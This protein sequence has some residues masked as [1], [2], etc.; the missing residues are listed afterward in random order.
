MTTAVSL[1]IAPVAGRIGARID[2]VRLGP[3][4][5]P[6]T[7]T[8][9]RDALLR[10]KV[11]FLPGQHHL[12]DAAHAG[13][14]RLLGELTTA[15]PTVPAVDGTAN[16]LPLDAEAG[17]KANQWHT[18]VTF[19][20]APPAFSVL[21]AVTIPPYG[22]DTSWA[23]TVTAYEELPPTLREL[24]ERLWALHSNLYDYAALKPE[25][26]AAD[27]AHYR[28]VF[29]RI[30][31]ETEHPV[32]RVHPETGERSLL[33][34]NFA[35]HLLGVP[36]ADSAHLIDLLQSHVSRLENTV[37]WRWSAG[38]VAIWDNRATQHYA[39]DDYGD[40][41][42]R[43][44]RVTIAGDVPVGVHGQRSV[45]RTGDATAYHA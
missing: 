34:G 20:D 37:R 12:D 8:A 13:F 18:D 15:H 4:L 22:G 7:V 11:I 35:Q 28:E 25:A 41:P 29:T 39:I 3:D 27:Q 45:S 9:I 32:V 33:L 23:N 31:F 44:H 5:D 17:G 16:V 14:A 1:A 24:A 30:N 38:D 42:R 10:H 2:G 21:R 26:S 19:V 36:K 40:Q 6:E 43:M